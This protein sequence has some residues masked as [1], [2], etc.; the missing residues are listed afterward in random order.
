MKQEIVITHEIPQCFLAD[1]L[2]MA[3]QAIN[4]CA[5][6]LLIYTLRPGEREDDKGDDQLTEAN[7]DNGP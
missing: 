2:S 5:D 3:E 1:N 4:G 6:F 7:K